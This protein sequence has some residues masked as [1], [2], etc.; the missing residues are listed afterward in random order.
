MSRIMAVVVAV[1]ACAVVAGCSGAPAEPVGLTGSPTADRTLT[2]TPSPTPTPTP[3]DGPQ[4]LSDPGVGIVF[5]GIP[6]LDGDSA[7][8]YNWIATFEKESWRTTTTNTVSP[9]MDVLASVEL[10]AS[11]QSTVDGNVQNGN[12]IGGV[13]HVRVDG[14][15]VDGGTARG[16]ACRDYADVTFSDASGSDTPEQAG[17]SQPR[18]ME[19]TLARVSGENRWTIMTLGWI[20]AC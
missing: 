9:G 7:D 11:V 17:F 12:H 8:V 16:T 5:E 1:V 10:R 4:D 15:T 14:I 2:S 3:S 19:L 6:A 20:G 13:L 18:L